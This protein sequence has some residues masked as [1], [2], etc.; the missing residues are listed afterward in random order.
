MLQEVYG[1]SQTFVKLMIFQSSYKI[2]LLDQNSNIPFL[3][4]VFFLQNQFKYMIPNT[5]N[6]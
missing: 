5:I 4:T 6:Q 1:L 2:N 3:Y